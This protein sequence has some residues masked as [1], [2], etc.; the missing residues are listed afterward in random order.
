MLYFWW[1]IIV[2]FSGFN[3]LFF[4]FLMNI[5]DLRFTCDVWRRLNNK[6]NVLATWWCFFIRV[7]YFDK[8]RPQISFWSHDITQKISKTQR[9]KNIET[10]LLQ[11]KIELLTF[12]LELKHSKCQSFALWNGQCNTNSRLLNFL[13]LRSIKE[14]QTFK[15]YYNDVF[16]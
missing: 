14:L 4:D 2:V 12:E 8:V 6:R 10:F 15:I 3:N 9:K 13:K 7:I 5:L 11:H 1:N 16:F